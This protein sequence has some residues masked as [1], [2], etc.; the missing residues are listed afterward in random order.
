MNIRSG[1][2]LPAVA[3]DKIAVIYGATRLTYGALAAEVWNNVVLLK[4]TAGRPV[5]IIASDPVKR[6]V[7]ALSVI[8]AGGYCCFLHPQADDTFK[9]Q[10]AAWPDAV[11]L[12]E[13]DHSAQLAH[14]NKI[15]YD[16]QGYIIP[17]TLV[18]DEA[19][20][21]YAT[22]GGILLRSTHA[23]P[24][25]FLVEQPALAEHLEHTI[26]EFGINENEQLLT[27]TRHQYHDLLEWL[28]PAIAAKATIHFMTNEWQPH[29]SQA[30]LKLNVHALREWLHHPERYAH[31]AA[32]RLVISSDRK[33]NRHLLKA[34]RKQYPHIPVVSHTWQPN[35]LPISVASGHLDAE[36]ESH[37]ADSIP[38]HKPFGKTRIMVLDEQK[39]A[40][41]VNVKGSLLVQHNCLVRPVMFKAHNAPAVPTGY[42]AR[43]VSGGK[44]QLI[45]QQ[46]RELQHGNQVFAPDETEE[47]VQAHPLVYHS[48][49]VQFFHEG[50]STIAAFAAPRAGERLTPASLRQWLSVHIPAA[51]MPR[52]F[53]VQPSLPLLPDGNVD[54]ALLQLPP[55]RYDSQAAAS[56]SES[57]I[58]AIWKETLKLDNIGPADDF[59]ALG[60]H[61]LL[62]TRTI[63]AINA[64]FGSSLSLKDIFI[65]STP[66][67][68]AARIA[69]DTARSSA[70]RPAPQPR[71]GRIPLSFSQERVWFIHRLQGSIP[72]HQTGWLKLSGKLDIAAL[73][74]ALLGI[75]QRH[76]VI[77]TLITE[78]DGEAFQQVIPADGWQL[79]YKDAAGFDERHLQDLLNECLLIPFDLR[80]DFML[81]ATLIRRADDEHQLLLVMHHIA[82]DGGSFPV[83]MQELVT[84][85]V[86]HT[87]QRAAELPPL[88]LQYADYA[89]WQRQHLNAAVLD[90]EVDYWKQQL[91][92]LSPLELPTD[93]ARP[94]IQSTAGGMVC[95]TL[96]KTLCNQLNL[97]ARQEG[98]T[99]YVLLLSAFKILMS[100]Y[101]GQQDIC[102]GV[103]VANRTHAELEP[104]VGFF[105][106]LLAIRTDMDGSEKVHDLLLTVKDTLMQAYAHQEVPF[107]KVVGVQRDLS[108]S[109]VFQVLFTLHSGGGA[110]H[111]R[112]KDLAL[113]ELDMEE[114]AIQ[115][116]L[117]VAVVE[118]NGALQVNFGYC[119]DLFKRSTILRMVQHFRQLLL[120]ILDNPYGK[121]AALP[122]ITA[123]ETALLHSFNDNALPY[124]LQQT[125]DELIDETVARYPNAVAI[126]HNNNVVDYT[127]LKQHA[128]QLAQHLLLS[129]QLQEEEIVGVLCDRSPL[130]PTAAYGI[131]KAGGAYLPI[132]PELPEERMKMILEDAGVK[133]IISE[134]KYAAIAAALA[135][136]VIYCDEPLP[137]ADDFKKKITGADNTRLAYVIYTSGST[138]R[139]K[140]A[141]VEHRGLINH[142]YAR[143]RSLEIDHRCRI[144]QNASQSF[145]ISIF[146]MFAAL[147]CGGTTVIYSQDVVLRPDEFLRRVSADG[148]TLMEIVPG[149][150]SLILDELP[151]NRQE[152]LF[153]A[154]QYMLA[155]GETLKKT[156][157][158]RWFAAF[159]HIKL[160]NG[161]GPTEASD[162]VTQYIM[163]ETPA[164][165]SI[166]IGKVL[167]NL[168]AYIVDKHG[169]LCPP[170]VPG[171]LWVS[172]AGVGRGYVNDPTKTAQ[173]FIKDPFN[174]DG[175]RLYK[176]GDLV[177]YLPDGNIEF[178]GRKDHQ[179][180]IRGY[181]I[182]LGEIEQRLNSLPGVKEA[183]VMD[184]EGNDRQLALYAYV[185]LNSA[186]TT[187]EQTM[188]AQLGNS[189]PAYMVPAHIMVLDAFPLT[190]NGKVDRRALPMP[191]AADAAVKA[192]VA[193]RNHIEAGMAAIWQRLLNIAAVS[194]TADF[195]ELGG[196][197]LLAVRVL[198]AIRN[199]LGLDI[200]IKD[201]F[202]HTTI[203]A[204]AAYSRHSETAALAAH[205]PLT[206]QERGVFIPLSFSQERLWFIDKFKGTQAYHLP[207]LLQLN[208]VA[209]VS[210]L[211]YALQETVNRHEVLRTLIRE[212]NGKGYQHILPP[213]GWQ[214][215]F[216]NAAAFPTEAALQEFIYQSI[217][218]PFDLA[219]DH[220]LQATLI[221]RDREEHLLLIILHHI[222][223]DGWSI[224]LL[225]KEL[226]LLYNARLQQ[227][228]AVL[229]ELALQYADYAIWQR[230][231]IKEEVLAKQ[232]HYWKEQLY[233]VEPLQLPTDFLRPAVQS[234]RGAVLHYHL[235]KTTVD[236]LEAL[237]KQQGVTLFTTM[238]AAFKVL[239]FR[240]S[241]QE[242]ICV[243]IPVAGRLQPELE[244]LIGFFVNTL[245]LRNNLAGN[246]SFA[247]LLQQLKQTTLDAYTNQDVPFEM[248]VDQLTITR[249]MSR[250]PVFQV[251]FGLN[252]VPA[253]SSGLAL[254]QLIVKEV[255][256]DR[257]HAR[258]DLTFELFVT[259][260]GLQLAVEYCTD[261]F[262]ATTAA[263]MAAHYQQ[264]LQSIL[265]AVDTPVLA[266]PLLPAGELQLLHSFNHTSAAFPLEN[267]ATALFEAAAARYAAAAAVVNGA[268]YLSYAELDR[269]SNQLAHYL[270]RIGLGVGK[271]AAVCMSRSEQLVVSI[272]AILKTG[273]AYVPVDPAY[274]QQRIAYIMSDTEAA[275]LIRDDAF[276]P[277]EGKWPPVLHIND[278]WEAAIAA[279]PHTA[280]GVDIR[281]SDLAY[282]IYTSGSTGE[283]KGVM[284][285]HRSLLNLCYWHTAAF[286][287]TPASRATMYAGIGFDAAVWEI[288]PYLLHGA[289]LYPV[290]EASKLDIDYLLDFFRHN[291]ITHTFLPTA[292]CE[293][294][295][296]HPAERLPLILTGGDQLKK[297]GRHLP[298]INNYGPTESTVVATSIALSAIA[299]T[300]PI[301]IG[302]PISNTQIYILNDALQLMPLGATGEIFVGGDSLARGYLKR[303]ALTAERFIAHPFQAGARLYRSGDLGRWLPDGT[304]EFMGRVDHQVKIRGYRV[305]LGEIENVMQQSGYVNQAVVLA[306]E[307]NGG[308]KQL[309]AYVVPQGTLDK[310]AFTD[311]LKGK[312][313]AYMVPAV[314]VPL[315]SLPLTP[316]G[317][318]DRKALPAPDLTELNGN[319]Y[320]S[321]RNELELTLAGIWQE[322]LGV[323]WVGIHD[324][325]FELGGD[326]II[327]IQLVSRAKRLGY[328]LQTKDVFSNQTIARLAAVMQERMAVQ[329][330]FEAE[331]GLLTGNAGLL[332]IQQWYLDG[333]PAE[334]SHFNQSILLNIDKQVRPAV[335]EK[336]IAQLIDHHDALRFVYTQQEGQW[337]QAY[338]LAPEGVLVVEQLGKENISQQIISLEEKYQQSLDIHTGAVMRVV[339]MQTPA[340][341]PYNRLLT[342]IHHLAVDGV[343]WRILLE[344]TELLITAAMNSE[345]ADLGRKTGSYRQ[346]RQS[347]E[348]YANTARL[349]QQLPYWEQVTNAY[350]ALP[351]DK[352]YTKMVTAKDI[353]S[354]AVSLDQAHTHQLLQEVSKVYRTDI[355]DILLAA[356]AATLADWSDSDRIVVGLEGH[357]REDIGGETDTSRT[358]GWFTN[359]YPVL[360]DVSGVDG[361]R[362]LVRNIKEQLRSIPDKGM[363][364]GALKYIRQTESLHGKDPWDIVFNYLGQL[365]NLVSHSRWFNGMD[366]ADSSNANVSAANRVGEKIAVTA[367]VENAQ[368]TLVWNYSSRHYKVSTIRELADSYLRVLVA[369]IQHCMAQSGAVYTPS[370]YGLTAEVSNE[371]LDLFFLQQ[372]ATEEED[373]MDSIL[374]F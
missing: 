313:P 273:A 74:H 105:L 5:F 14:P 243:G 168:N 312:L 152:P 361:E 165:D 116:D 188:K 42:N 41:P 183:I 224:P 247:E 302:R 75:V 3:A 239:L 98:V 55:D 355:N 232:L 295:A 19:A 363:G 237:S 324:N 64:A 326:S 241:N 244:P 27:D 21:P 357:G 234:N 117:D 125:I 89:I 73:E 229:P 115:F 45:N 28:L 150:L 49:V 72:F 297:A 238:L 310:E 209:D 339:L 8:E 299:E 59:F 22:Q 256:L 257:E 221:S 253:A 66:A 298:V 194:V 263:R 201:F 69:A 119:S 126:K 160:V 12:T 351:V 68:L 176:T 58:I 343:S 2:I 215:E 317:K 17:S 131:W 368:L 123:E 367:M 246:I 293:Q 231:H 269:R 206:V 39:R 362:D 101:S 124:P 199:E 36:E 191:D 336:V 149:Y 20:P 258:F 174:K 217:Q 140:G 132:H 352:N 9:Q 275:L 200:S 371:E 267:T 289:A 364:Y 129:A 278:D 316:N 156:L 95:M 91:A 291:G 342:I 30:L 60:G 4:V 260:E 50:A 369:V 294:L 235:P 161:Y 283:P 32:H 159:P 327:T 356:L 23:A 97:L 16:A 341:E 210:A 181:R 141:M 178:I 48:A 100:R 333:A 307:D 306:R 128:E 155:G 349:Q 54:T 245:A 143:I 53:V 135:V 211:Q 353:R 271:L 204:L 164:T 250:N 240:H 372:G 40:T 80:T 314:L 162:T 153:P 34:W 212:E 61:S 31:I 84:L 270:L 51:R 233:G 171:E 167:P 138:G 47:I 305:E 251:A 286:N 285:E 13:K 279:M 323:E 309:V 182:E 112:I 230:Q 104:L 56:E 335:L 255:A 321:P 77:R 108:R 332:P 86:A 197:S 111:F 308:H 358:V 70:A 216:V 370:D 347:L 92:G 296:D 325:F 185:T 187:D 71:E 157:A 290:A 35:G 222:A 213:G 345:H 186:R 328:T 147:L 83:I 207:F 63:A 322:L 38:L 180:K 338:G 146:Q 330:A 236:A 145:D 202:T 203:E 179:V 87:E 242:D 262:T 142:Q 346:W 57:R 137:A 184:R 190:T 106:N 254:D 226:A 219:N 26:R 67:L 366:E 272:L 205:P 10:V 344:D 227:R 65:H 169:A 6:V 268:R 120:S 118:T 303:E 163:Q 94:A 96:E 287:V 7:L 284:V 315:E 304:I 228:M 195:F 274:P 329:A 139:P 177:R 334:V 259:E 350:T 266:L 76:E 374:N 281:P 62:A 25:A 331:Q 133:V 166:S 15:I 85:Y 11:V 52:Y 136:Q 172:G 113:S 223:G 319:V 158:A 122:M 218:T 208:G 340:S 225:A 252:N 144:A 99:L 280:T 173:S 264:L 107:E 288:W 44:I 214:L 311:Y 1:K 373:D 348:L 282:V 265:Q 121:V 249:D 82:T 81:R 220:P 79:Q 102:V 196:H 175:G 261:L 130:L 103:P 320:T 151:E 43:F 365:D 134:R 292:I 360:L 301:S 37:I 18:M 276:Q 148:I 354:I 29:N 189:L 337:Q 154:L 198:S 318:I 110:E 109:P 90:R 33:V 93:F 24:A 192:M 127:Q 300:A 193:P 88:P 170:G 248:V 114:R 277:A 46:H 78:Q 359:L